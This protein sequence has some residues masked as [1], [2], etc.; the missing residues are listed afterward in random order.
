M[1][2]KTFRFAWRLLMLLSATLAI[3][4]IIY[5]EVPENAC[6]NAAG[7]DWG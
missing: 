3:A 5:L 1:T 2:Q 6:L 7:S 4:L